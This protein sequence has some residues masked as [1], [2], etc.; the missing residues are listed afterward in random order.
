MVHRGLIPCENK[1]TTVLPVVCF[2]EKCPR[3]GSKVPTKTL[4]KTLAHGHAHG[5]QNFD[6]SKP[7][8]TRQPSGLAYLPVV[9]LNTA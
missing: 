2:N 9:N 6:R 1:K 7:L 5:T 3:K 4:S 8:A